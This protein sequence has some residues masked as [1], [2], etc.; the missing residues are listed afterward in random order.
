MAASYIRRPRK[1]RCLEHP[2]S[3]PIALPGTEIAAPSLNE[4][5]APWERRPLDPRPAV[6]GSL[7]LVLCS[8][9]SARAIGHM[10]RAGLR[11]TRPDANSCRGAPPRARPRCGHPNGFVKSRVSS[12]YLGLVRILVPDL[13]ISRYLE[14]PIETVL[15]QNRNFEHPSFD[16][17]QKVLA[18][19][20]S[21]CISS[22]LMFEPYRTFFDGG[23]KW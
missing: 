21:H 20:G 10:P 16:S 14:V 6:S 8:L 23:N 22:H 5:H 9:R 18:L 13:V 3:I 4:V 17:A 2:K 11:P 12:S 19:F 7:S 15:G 1:G